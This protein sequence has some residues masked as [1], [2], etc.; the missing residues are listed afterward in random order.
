MASDANF[1]NMDF[2]LNFNQSLWKL[3]DNFDN[4]YFGLDAIDK[5]NQ[6]VVLNKL[7][8]NIYEPLAALGLKDCL[9]MEQN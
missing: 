2:K 4:L 1:S 3:F 5:S 8:T 7:G 6:F 9:V